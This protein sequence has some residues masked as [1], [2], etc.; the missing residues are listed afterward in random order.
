MFAYAVP[1]SYSD[2]LEDLDNAKESLMNN[3]SFGTPEYC[4]NGEKDEEL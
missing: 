2:L 4:H 1:Y 3:K